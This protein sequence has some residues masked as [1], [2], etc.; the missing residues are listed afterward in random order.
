MWSLCVKLRRFIAHKRKKMRGKD[1]MRGFR[2]TNKNKTSI[3]CFY[4]FGGVTKNLLQIY[5][6]TRR[7][8]ILNFD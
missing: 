7:S 8:E 4:T 1:Q 2:K 3:Q 6:T 5:I